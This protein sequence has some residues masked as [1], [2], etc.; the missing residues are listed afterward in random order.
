MTCHDLERWL[1]DGS[2]EADRPEALAHARTC[3]RCAAVLRT[4]EEIEGLLAAAPAAPGG[5]ADRVMMRVE[6]TAQ[7]SPRAFRIELLPPTIPWWVRVTLEPACILALI[8]VA[9][10]LWRGNA[11]VA[12]ASTAATQV[13]LWL[14]AMEANAPSGPWSQ[15]VVLTCVLLGAAPLALLASQQL[16]RWSEALVGPRHLRLRV[17]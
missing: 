13:G 17:H 11:L 12:L 8:L 15:P 9:M 2:P 6:A 5:F 14:T 4:A 16:Y 7:I 3:P 1:D 10:L